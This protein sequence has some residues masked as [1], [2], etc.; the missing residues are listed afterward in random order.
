MCNHINN[1]GIK[2]N[3]KKDLLFCKR[4]EK[5]N[6][7]KELSLMEKEDYLSDKMSDF[8]INL[9]SYCLCG[10]K[11]TNEYKYK[12]FKTKKHIEYIK[13]QKFNINTIQNE[14]LKFIKN[15]NSIYK[16]ENWRNYF[17]DKFL[18]INNINYYELQKQLDELILMKKEDILLQK[19]LYEFRLMKKE[20]K[21]IYQKNINNIL[22]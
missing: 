3:L 10:S 21:K 5:S 4:H 7:K 11:F 22:I 8:G 13:K 17:Y 18:N 6:L 9:I 1:K 20:D 19:Q 14:N 15:I 2:C 12:H 16:G